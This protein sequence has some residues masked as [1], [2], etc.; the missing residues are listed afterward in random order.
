[1]WV[2]ESYHVSAIKYVWFQI[3]WGSFVGGSSRFQKWT[4]I[5]NLLHH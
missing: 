2:L 5:D 4:F 1:M 3:N